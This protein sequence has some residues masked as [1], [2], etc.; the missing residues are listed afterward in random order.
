M[1][2]RR[3]SANGTIKGRSSQRVDSTKER[4]RST[5]VPGLHWVLS[6]L[7]PRVLADCPTPTRPHQAGDAMALGRQRASRVRNA[8]RQNGQQAGPTTTKLRQ[9]LLP[10]NRRIQVRSGGSLISG[11]GNERSNATKAAPR[12]ILLRHLLPH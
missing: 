4:P 11:R 10:P 6:L 9:N 12:R 3:D 7:Y 2:R 5:Q 8:P 1:C